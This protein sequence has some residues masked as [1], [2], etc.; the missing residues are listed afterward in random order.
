VVSATEEGDAFGAWRMATRALFRKVLA[1]NNLDG[2][3]FPQAST[4]ITKLVEDPARPDYTPNNHPEIPSNIIND[5]GIPTVT[6]PFSYYPDKT[7]FV[8]AFIGDMWT[9]ANLLSWAYDFEQA[10]RSRRAPTL[11]P[12]P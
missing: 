7:P 9:E 2:L 6:V 10:T 11:V 8:V 4:P 12:K 5:I 3:F 1:D